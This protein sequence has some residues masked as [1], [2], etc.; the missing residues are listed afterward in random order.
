MGRHRSI[1]TL[2]A[3]LLAAFGALSLIPPAAGA[4]TVPSVL[5][6][7][8]STQAS[9]V[10]FCQGNLTTRVK[11]F[12]GVPLDTNV[13]L[14]PAS[15]DGP[16]PLIVELHGFGGSKNGVATERA[17]AGYAVLS[18]TARGFGDSCG[19]ITSRGDPGC[20]QGW[21][22][23]ADARYEARDTQYLAGLL[24][25]AGLARPAIGVTGISYGGV[26]A[27]I[28]AVLK[29]R[30]MK[31]DGNFAPWISPDG[32]PMR[33]AAAAPLIPFSD[34]LAALLPNGRQLD[35]D[36][37]ATYGSRIGVPKLSYIGFLSGLLLANYF[38]PPGADPS[39]D[40]V[41]WVARFSAGEPYEGDPSAEAIVDE[42]RS[43]HNAYYLQDPLPEAQR[44][45]P[46]PLLIYNAWTDDLNPV[47][48]ATVFAK[49][50]GTEFP[51]S[52]ISMFF[53]AGFGHPR[54]DLTASTPVL[55]QRIGEFFGRHLK[56]AGGDPL[57][58]ET[59]TQGC[60]NDPV[61]GPFITRTWEQQHPGEVRFG[62]SGERTI[63][64]S[65]GD[66]ATAAAVDPF[67]A[68]ATQG[69]VTTPAADDPGSVNY[70]GPEV[71][72]GGYTLLGA[73][74]VIARMRTTEPGSEVAARL[75]DVSPDGQ[76][77]F[78]A[79]TIYRPTVNSDQ[80][81]AFQLH[82]N[83]WRFAPGHVPKL[84]LLGSDAP[85]ARA[86]N[87]SFDVRV[88]DLELRLPV[89]EKPGG[90]VS[91]PAT[92]FL[93]DLPR[94]QRGP[95]AGAQ[96]NRG[97]GGRDVLVGTLDRDQLVGRAG[98]DLLRG[99][100]QADCL[101]AGVSADRLEGGTGS[102]LLR[103]G[104]GSD[105][106]R[107]EGGSDRLAGGRGR[108]GLSGS[109]GRDRLGGGPGGDR[110]VGGSG[111]DRFNGGTGR[112]VCVAERGERVRGCEVV[113]RR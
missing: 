65:G 36:P 74:T 100:G 15:V 27:M 55:D 56:G 47:D 108:D 52:E 89:R 39:A 79:R 30:I 49:R 5:G 19:T 38:A 96:L 68:I 37:G 94:A 99:E 42:I 10:Q 16:Y 57:G 18:Y 92:P 90:Q 95:C 25:D 91:T 67:A 32:T 24:V 33:I 101:L 4:E 69:C 51:G 98:K 61:E 64:S 29:N 102:D 28:L 110:L 76:Q 13:T 3:A 104:R 83:G 46:A 72:G 62:D 71:G 21:A 2:L 8:C 48:Q 80:L 97:S 103:G 6:I 84:E 85:Y 17:N 112:D 9:G 59:F 93:P 77:R 11:T 78:V 12:D 60:G 34:F 106:M 109:A 107:G 86:S 113:Q 54:A 40:G 20:A 88:S 31:P 53:S 45:A 23:L 73:P 7:P 58:V 75:W 26:Q 70:R 50:F 111:R 82:G 1:G 14:P 105:R 41:G 22:H 43:F 66:P 81:Q 44:E 35:Y 87:A 63:S